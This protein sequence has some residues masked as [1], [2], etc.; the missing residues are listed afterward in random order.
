[1]R[2]PEPHAAARAAVVAVAILVAAA[3]TA[4]ATCTLQRSI[5]V[6]IGSS[7]LRVDAG[8]S[9]DVQPPVGDWSAIVLDGLP[10]RV[11]RRYLAVACAEGPLFTTTKP[12][13]AASPASPTS[14][15]ESAPGRASTTTPA[16]ASATTS[17]TTTAWPFPA[18]T[19][20]KPSA[21][22]QMRAVREAAQRGDAPEA[23]VAHAAL[24]RV[25]DERCI[26]AY[27]W[28][29]WAHHAAGDD[30]AALATWDD[31]WTAWDDAPSW[32][33]GLRSMASH[34]A[35]QGRLATLRTLPV[36]L[37][38]VAGASTAAP[39][40]SVA[41][42]TVAAPLRIAVVG[43]VHLGRNWPAERAVVPPAEGAGFFDDVA[44]TLQAATLTLANLETALANTGTSYKC[45][46]R[47][48]RAGFCFSFRAPTYMAPRVAAAGIDVVSL[49]NNHAADFG[50]AGLRTTI[51]SLHAAGVESIG[52]GSRTAS[53]DVQGTRVAF[54]AFSVGDLDIGMADLATM[55]SQIARLDA[56]H[57]VVVVMF[58]G[59]AEGAGQTHVPRAVEHYL[60]EYRGDV[61]AFAH[62]A[63]D[64]G[65]DL[66]AGSG[67]HVL[68][69]VE[70]YR[71]RVIAYS[72]GNFSSWRT[73]PTNGVFA[74]SG[75]LSVD[76][77]PDGVALAAQFTS[78][79]MEK[80]GRPV[81]DPE[82]AGLALVRRVSSEDFG[83]PFFDE[84]GRWVRGRAQPNPM[85]ATTLT[86]SL[87]AT[88]TST[89]GPRSSTET[90][91]NRSAQ[92]RTCTLVRETPVFRAGRFVPLAVGTV[93]TLRSRG[94]RFTE[95]DSPDGPARIAN[96]LLGRCRG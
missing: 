26:E 58:H 9:F 28:I 62:A 14:P 53:F 87:A 85:T 65:A 3:P 22:R 54:A 75:I 72:L 2:L 19:P 82:G 38:A 67:P 33:L 94:A 77:A 21:E 40:G 23:I 27:A 49:A 32:A 37:P 80:S 81:L 56:T 95:V 69:G 39:P 89:S 17:P 91:A 16:T 12:P 30:V 83:A 76:L 35:V 60:D 8:D 4:A 43:D 41:A 90:P 57:D 79:T 66:V 64:A 44:P 31:L 20:C 42:A 55:Q 52:I 70:T 11:S 96:T 78:T 93:L 25:V 46:A 29:A 88:S 59:G 71:G 45:S 18:P 73:F 5:K 92:E 47:T 86:S 63:V 68:R 50:Y 10:G 34:V 51:D 7:I 24:A 15:E 48:K 1:M 84:S 36:A 74:Q 61:H 6:V 13:E